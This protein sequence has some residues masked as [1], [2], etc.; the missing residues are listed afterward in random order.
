VQRSAELVERVLRSANGMHGGVHD[1]SGYQR[2]T[3]VTKPLG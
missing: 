2:Y 1:R 3:V